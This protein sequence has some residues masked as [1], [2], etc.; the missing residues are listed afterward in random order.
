M[1][2]LSLALILVVSACGKQE[3]KEKESAPEKGETTQADE[4]EKTIP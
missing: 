2:M 3:A 1:L 4:P